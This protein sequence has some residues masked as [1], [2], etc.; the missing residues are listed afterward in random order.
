MP[1][2]PDRAAR[3]SVLPW[4]HGL[5]LIVCVSA[6]PLA[7]VLDWALALMAGFD[8]GVIA[9]LATMPRL[10]RHEETTIRANAR[11]NDANRELFLA[12]TFVTTAA[13]LV[14]V[15]T[16]LTA[17]K[18]LNSLAIALVLVTLLLA[19]I[20]SNLVYALHY[21]YLFYADD[22]GKDHGGIRFA[23]R[24]PSP[25]YGDFAYF[26]FT[27][28]MTFQTSD[29]EIESRSVRTVALFHSMAAFVFNIGVIAFT[30][31]ILG[32]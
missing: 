20:F 15:G 26:A 8:L 24:E 23:G 3:K 28:G 30:I 19:W 17:S 2:S 12:I 11:R 21:A 5:F 25:D 22:G 31:N 16:E 4:R 9:F 10:F 7:L 1:R 29:C 13:I 6:L 14:A 32:G 27:L 18:D